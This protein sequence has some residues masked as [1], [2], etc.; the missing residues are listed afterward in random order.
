MSA[1]KG[2]PKNRTRHD[3]RALIKEIKAYLK[4][5]ATEE[6]W[7]EVWNLK[8][9]RLI[10]D[11]HLG[12]PPKT[13]VFD[14]KTYTPLT[15]FKEVTGLN[16]DAYISV[17]STARHPWYTWQVLDAP[18]NWRRN[19]EYLNAPLKSWFAALQK[20]LQSG[21]TVVIGGDVSEPGKVPE[22]DLFFVPTFDI[23]SSLINQ[24]SRELRIANRSTTDDH[25]IHLL[26]AHRSKGAKWFVFKDSGRSSRY[27]KHKGY[28]F[29]SADY[30]KLKILTWYGHRSLAASLLQKATKKSTLSPKRSHSP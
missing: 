20:G 26:G 3:H 13:V 23:P 5:V 4:F 8:H 18:D 10:L 28:Y 17:I 14:V 22:R 6:L 25:G 7:D 16:P 30:L 29:V 24:H 2:L 9:V 27:G 1:Y 12:P 11:R 19:G 21:H 15:F